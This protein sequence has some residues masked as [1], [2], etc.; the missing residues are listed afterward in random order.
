[1]AVGA[2]YNSPYIRRLETVFKIL[3]QQLIRGRHCYR[4]QLVQ[5]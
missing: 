1:M 4:P 2:T 5:T 3:L